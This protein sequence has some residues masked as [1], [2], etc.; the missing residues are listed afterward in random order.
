M[1]ISGLVIVHSRKTF[2]E[3]SRCQQ[4]R[5]LAPKSDQI[6]GRHRCNPH[7]YLEFKSPKAWLCDRLDVVHESTHSQHLHHHTRCSSCRTNVRFIS[8]IGILK[9]TDPKPLVTENS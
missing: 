2:E 5:E 8:D 4:C 3:Y 1:V 9:N 6:G 7:L